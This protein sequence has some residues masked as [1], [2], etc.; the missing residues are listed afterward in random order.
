MFPGTPVAR[1]GAAGTENK[2]AAIAAAKLARAV[3]RL[4]SSR[5]EPFRRDGRVPI[6]LLPY[7]SEACLCSR[8]PATTQDD[9][10]TNRTLIRKLARVRRPLPFSAPRSRRTG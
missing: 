9:V 10:K 6:R 7:F 5:Q 8:D 2:N 3:V 4:L 1:A